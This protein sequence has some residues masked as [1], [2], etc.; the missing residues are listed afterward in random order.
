LADPVHCIRT[1]GRGSPGSGLVSVIDDIVGLP[2]H[3]CMNVAFA[4][5]QCE[6]T[7]RAGLS[8]D[9]AAVV[10]PQC[11]TRVLTPRGAL[12]EGQLRRCVVCPSTDLYL[13]KDFPQRLGVLLVV[14][15]FAA[16][17]VAWYFYAIYLTFGILLATAL[18]DVVLYVVCGEALQCYRCGAIYRDVPGI[19]DHAPF[20]LDVHERHRQQVAR[21]ESHRA[22]DAKKSLV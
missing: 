21:E 6:Q 1:I 13:R 4:C 12:E 19:E 22:A 2:Y 3:R 5:P 8:A 10:C 16:S 14:L 11:Q 17:C 7:V 20:N 15:G 9:T 18:V